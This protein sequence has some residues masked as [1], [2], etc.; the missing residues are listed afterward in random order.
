MTT[1]KQFLQDFTKDI[2]GDAAHR[3]ENIEGYARIL[4]LMLDA[5]RLEELEALLIGA[6][7]APLNDP[8]TKFDVLTK[9]RI[10]ELKAPHYMRGKG[11]I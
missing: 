1:P 6:Y 9:Q 2:V 11:D 7:H 4:E 8:E 5:A 3:M 10:A